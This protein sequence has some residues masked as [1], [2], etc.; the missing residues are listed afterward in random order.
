M[1]AGGPVRRPIP[2][3]RAILWGPAGA[4]APRPDDLQLPVFLAQSALAAIHEHL[5]TPPG[6]GQGLLGFLVGDLCECPETGVSYLVI[7]AALRLSQTIYHD[8]TRDVVTHL[9]D[10]IQAQIEAQ[11]A[12]LIGWYHTHESLP[13]A[14]SPEDV[15]THE[16]YFAEPWQVALLLGT[17]PA[18][19]AGALLRASASEG[20]TAAPLPFYE[21]LADESLHGGRRRSFVTWRNYRAFSPVAPQAPGLAR[22]PAVAAEGESP[23]PARA[24]E[25]EPTSAAPVPEPPAS[26]P[27]P[28]PVPQ[29]RPRTRELEFLTTAEDFA[30]TP[31]AVP[32]APAPPPPPPPAAAPAPAVIAR[33]Q[34]TGDE[35]ES[36]EAVGV[37]AGAAETAEPAGPRLPAGPARRGGRALRRPKR[38]RR[39]WRAVTALALVAAAGGAY[40]WFRPTFTPPRVAL[41]PAVEEFAARLTDAWARRRRAPAPTAAAPPLV[42]ADALA[43]LAESVR[44]ALRSLD[45]RAVLFDR[46]QSDCA[47]LAQSLAAVEVRWEAYARSRAGTWLDAAHRL[48]DERLFAAL[49][50]RERHFEQTGCRRP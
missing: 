9:W 30:A 37:E 36:R 39:L 20:W 10:R 12:H 22:P 41:P 24:A 34:P 19:P 38:G 32:A 42:A 44:A 2:I 16:H 21:L 8:R 26:P 46:R 49:D 50:G 35:G 25:P 18:T 13:L 47:A 48:L 3:P 27:E 33:P 43:P 45:E 15:E 29:P 17:D 5:A 40:A 11:Q 1:S 7:D 4:A 6:P 28:G 31:R 23:P 14:L